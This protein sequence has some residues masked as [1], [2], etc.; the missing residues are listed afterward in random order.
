MTRP[1]VSVH[2]VSGSDFV[3]PL[4]RA[5]GPRS[6]R[7]SDLAQAQDLTNSRV[8]SCGSSLQNYEYHGPILLVYLEYHISGPQI[9]LNMMF[10]GIGAIMSLAAAIVHRLFLCCPFRSSAMPSQN[11]V[12]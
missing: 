12:P 3:G 10:V 5:V 7:I 1:N 9:D 4:E 11:M 6:A 8:L 2:F